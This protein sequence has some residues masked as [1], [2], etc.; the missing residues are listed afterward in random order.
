[1]V[2]V[3][4]SWN[5]LAERAAKKTFACLGL[6]VLSHSCEEQLPAVCGGC[7]EAQATDV[8]SRGLQQLCL[9]GRALH[10]LSPQIVVMANFPGD[11]ATIVSF[12]AVTALTYLVARIMFGHDAR[13]PPLAPQSIPIIGHMIGLSRSSFNYYVDLR[14]V[15]LRLQLG[16]KT[17][18]AWQC[19]VN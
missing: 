10:R 7:E 6:G 18:M 19:R 14:Y 8:M 2:V 3:T 1:M 9:R 17:A 4:V 16:R 12:T 15:T 5:L 13:E 11:T